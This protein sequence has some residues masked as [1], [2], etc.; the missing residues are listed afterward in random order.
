V[1]DPKLVLWGEGLV[2]LLSRNL[3]GAGPLHTVAPTVVVRRWGGRAD[4]ES[5]AELGRRTGAGLALY[6]SLLSA[7][8]D[9]VRVR[10]TLFDVARGRAV[11]EWE[12]GEAREGLVRLTEE[13]R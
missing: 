12:L 2:D 1:L 5:A 4:P 9:S 6:G 13:G 3:D 7:G 8:R 11:D 10:A